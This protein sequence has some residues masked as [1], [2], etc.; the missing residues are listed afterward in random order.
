[1]NATT[2]P[3]LVSHVEL[4]TADADAAAAV[5]ADG[6]GF[7]IHATAERHGPGGASRSLAL[8]QGGIVLV[9]T[10]ALDGTHPAAGFVGRH[11]DGVADIALRT[12][13][14]RAAFTAAVAR[15]ATALAG[16]EERD[17]WVTAVLAAGFDDVRHTLVQRPAGHEDAALPLPGFEPVAEPA[18]ASTGTPG[19]TVL[20]HV[21]VSVP[22]GELA[23]STGY[24]ERIFGFASVYEELMVQGTEAMDSKAVRSPAGDLTFTVLAPS[25][26]HDAG[27][28]GDFLERHGGG[29][30][31]HLA[32][33]TDDIVQAV[34]RLDDRGVDFLHTPDTY[35]ELLEKRLEPGRHTLAELR[36]SRILADEDHAGQ[37]FQIFTRTVHPRRTL[38]YEIIERS[39]A[40]TFGGGNVRALYEAVQ[41]DKPDHEVVGETVR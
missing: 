39:G 34:A 40:D 13:D 27:H 30:V 12:P 15:S 16:P 21:A 1:M 38:F 33:A 22:M 10:E 24:Y 19:L 20:D 41:A 29:G 6:Y 5:F 2:G 31:H 28:I 25:P 4:Y 17:G 32:F 18:P 14:T 35:Y 7:Q 8:R 26:D 37:L 36:G 9:V 11:G 23:E 3:L